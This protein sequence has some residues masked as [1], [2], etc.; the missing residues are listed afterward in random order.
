VAEKIHEAFDNSII[1]SMDNYY[2]G[3]TFMDEQKAK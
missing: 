2:K 3:H 1:I